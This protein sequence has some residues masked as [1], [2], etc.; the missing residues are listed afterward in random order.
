[1]FAVTGIGHTDHLHIGHLGMG[2]KNL[3][4]LARIDGL[5]A[6]DHH[7]LDPAD[8]AQV[9]VVVHRREV[10]S[11]HPAVAQHGR[12]ELGFVPVSAHDRVTAGAEFAGLVAADRPAGGRIDHL[13]LQVRVYGDDGEHPALQAVVGLSLGGDRRGLGHAV[14]DRHL[15]AA[16]LL[17]HPLH[18]LDRAG[19]A[20][21][22]PGA[23]RAEVVAGEV[24]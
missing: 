5:A 11:V 8:H 1:M 21:H 14:A 7:V 18:D 15:A 23:Q 20:G 6:A 13:H 22:D 16:H 19:R 24:G 12:A 10:T 3:L 9:A 17:D 2:A 4:D